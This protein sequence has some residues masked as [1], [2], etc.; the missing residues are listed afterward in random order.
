M[1]KMLDEVN[2]IAPGTNTAG[3][4]EL[5]YESYEDKTTLNVSRKE[6]FQSRKSRGNP[7]YPLWRNIPRRLNTMLSL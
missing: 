4:P 5:F 2:R 6:Y 3:I 1:A 7:M